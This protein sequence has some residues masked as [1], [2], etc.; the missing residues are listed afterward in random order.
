MSKQRLE[1]LGRRRLSL[2]VGV[3]MGLVIAAILPLLITL[4]FS[5]WQARPALT[6]QANTSMKSDA[7]TRV[8]LIDTYFS[9]RLLDTQTLAQVPS[10]QDFLATNAAPTSL[11]YKDL[12]VHALYALG[13]GIFRD[14]HYT[15]WVLFTPQ[16]QPALY[17]PLN[18][19]PKP[20]GKSFAAP[21]Y[22]QAVRAGKTFATDVYY[23]PQTGKPSVDIYSPIITPPGTGS[24]L[25]AHKYLGFIRATLNLDYIWNIVNEDLGS[26]GTGSYAFILDQNGV[27]ITDTDPARRFEAVEQ[28]SDT[29]QQQ[30]SNE[31]RYGTADDV[32][33]LPDPTMA[34]ELKNQANEVTF[35]VQPA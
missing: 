33:V 29:A 2:S 24:T 17:Y 9:E 19:P 32:P 14:K 1:P 20:R 15:T 6:A 11:Q 4:L 23:T 22:L 26:N 27:R 10:V 28:V 34:T 18:N 30:I 31:L 16:G 3:S 5:E 25:P 35:Q 13:A 8:Q 12:A 21:Q 7:K